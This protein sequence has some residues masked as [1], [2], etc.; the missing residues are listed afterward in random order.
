[1]TTDRYLLDTHVL[2]WLV[3]GVRLSSRAQAELEDAAKRAPLLV[4]P[5]TAW[6]LGLLAHP[7][8]ARQPLALKPDLKTWYADILA[9]G[10][11]AETP[12]SSDIALD[13]AL[14]PGE[15][16]GDPADRLLAATARSIGATLATRDSALLA[17]ARQGHVSVLPC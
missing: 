16:H 3:D 4:S 14:L 1:M 13:A 17:Y 6:E 10:R 12:F 2:I 9:S 8:G 5:V 11:F 7:R 15:L